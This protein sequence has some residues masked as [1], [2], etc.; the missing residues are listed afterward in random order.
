[1]T[2]TIGPLESAIAQKQGLSHDQ[3][4]IALRNSR[5]LLRLVNQLLDL[6]R[7]DAGRMQPSFRPCELVDFVTQTVESFRAYCQKK[8]ISLVTNLVPCPPVYLDLEKFDKVLYN[9]LSNA[10]KFTLKGGSIR[11][12]LQPAGDHCLLKVRDTGIGIRPDQM[13]HLF[14]RFR[15]AEGSANRSYEGS[16]LGLALVRELVELHGGQI[17]VDSTYGEGTTFTVWLQTG[18]SHLPRNR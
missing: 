18:V 6:Q 5:R 2:L 17:T 11:V 12:T 13:P 9:L 14:E 3:A 10:M 1:M 8:G 16:G 15:Q 7:L 4:A